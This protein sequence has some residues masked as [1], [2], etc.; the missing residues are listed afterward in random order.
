MRIVFMGSPDFAVPSL[1]VLSKTDNE[2]VAVITGAD[3]IRARGSELTPTPVKAKALELNL[4]VFSFE[5]MKDASFADF[6]HS[7][8]PD[9]ILIVAF[10]ILPKQILDIPT[11]G[12]VNIHASLLPKYRGAAPIHWA[13]VNGEKETGVSLFFLTEAI[14][15]GKIL[16][17]K[18][19]SISEDETTGD[20]Y[21]KLMFLGAE[22]IPEALQLIRNKDFKAVEQDD[23]LACP[24]PKVF[25]ETAHIKFDKSASEVHNLIRGMNPAPG[26]WVLLNGKKMKIHQTKLREE[27]ELEM[28]KLFFIGK[29][30]FI[31]CKT[32]ALELLIVQ[33][34]GKSKVNALSFMNGYRGE[35]VLS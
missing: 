10:K 1:E 14:D 9:L 26:S 21:S 5:S 24:A 8:K 27:L 12:S 25:P 11:I 19:T 32:G 4:P 17:Q 31:G 23:S 7:L 20:I 13:V 34:E 18:T 15:A 28:G 2:I 3:K 22:A 30:V 35:K 33:L 16:L 6:M 29:K